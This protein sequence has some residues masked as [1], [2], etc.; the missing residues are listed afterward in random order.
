M[1]KVAKRTPDAG[2]PPGKRGP[3]PEEAGLTETEPE[4]ED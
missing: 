1:A 4:S 3:I 2:A